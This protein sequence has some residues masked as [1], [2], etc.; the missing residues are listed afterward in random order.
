MA[1]GPQGAK[2][3]NFRD[4]GVLAIAGAVVTGAPDVAVKGISMFAG[5]NGN[6]E[7]QS[8]SGGLFG[9]LSSGSN[10]GPGFGSMAAALAMAGTMGALDGLKSLIS[11]SAPTQATGINQ[12]TSIA[13]TASTT[14]P[15]G[16]HEANHD[17]KVP[18]YVAVASAPR[19][20][21]ALGLA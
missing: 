21:G 1:F 6:S 16:V 7:S 4:G 3:V 11:P 15:T 17:L 5:G 19:N 10:D 12:D 9:G 2:Q 14:L 8:Q 20:S 18:T 13:A